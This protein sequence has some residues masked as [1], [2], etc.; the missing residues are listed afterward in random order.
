M[1]LEA[2]RAELLHAGRRMGIA[3]WLGHLAAIGFFAFLV[4]YRQRIDFLDASFLLAYALLPCLLA[5]PLVAESV[6]SRLAT[7]PAEG[8]M[9]QVLTPF[10]MGVIWNTVILSVAFAVVNYYAQAPRLLLPNVRV[11]LHCGILSLAATF[12]ACSL[13]GWLALNSKTAAAAKAQSRR[14]FLLVLMTVVMFVRLGPA[15]AKDTLQMRLTADR[16]HTLT[17]PVSL[18]LAAAGYAFLH[19][20]RKRRVEECAG[21]IFKI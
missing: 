8:Y 15:G 18:A 19:A 11:L 1:F 4:P 3:G 16:I 7:P 2:I 20:G 5:A 14:L 17:L 21:P 12:I 10:G 6:A 13:T 9:A